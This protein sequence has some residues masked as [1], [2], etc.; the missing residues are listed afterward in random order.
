MEILFVSHKYPPAVGG[1][2]KQSLELI[3]GMGKIAKV[4]ALVY[5]GKGSRLGFFISLEKRIMRILESFPSISII[6]FNDALIATVSL[7]HKRYNHIK[8]VVTVHGLDIVFPSTRYQKLIL[9]K[10]NRFDLIIAVSDATAKA[11]VDRGIDKKKVV[12]IC[13]GVDHKLAITGSQDLFLSYFR[14]KYGLNLIGKTILLAIGRPV[15]RK[16]FSWF[17]ENVMPGVHGNFIVLFVGPFDF[18]RP[19]KDILWEFC[20][21]NIKNKLQLMFGY[22]SD[23]NNLRHQ[24]HKHELKNKVLHLG[25]LPQADLEMILHH[26][27]GFIMPN[28]PVEGDMEGFG[29]VCLEASLAGNW[30]FASNIEGI[31]SAV[32]NEKNGTLLPTLDS[33]AW[34]QALNDF[35]ENPDIFNSV[36]APDY[37][38]QNFGWDK[39]VRQ[40][41]EH[42]CALQEKE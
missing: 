2:E 21:E 33:Q 10:F 26:S 15:K 22:P 13:N 34:T 3:T 23:E 11:C 27:D 30:V 35:I 40:Y 9:P 7:R 19:W 32:H 25:K 37:T 36:Q 17:L 41:Y 8:R 14:E 16:G 24:L 31:T 42:F 5:E 28:I 38:A 39:M 6:H 29:L 20:P 18:K 1:M 4:H 12:T